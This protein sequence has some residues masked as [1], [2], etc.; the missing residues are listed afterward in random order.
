MILSALLSFFGG[1]AFRYAL[2]RVIDWLEAKQRFRE[3]QARNEQQEKFDQARHVRQI[4]LIKLQSDLK[5]T[6]VKLI[7][8]QQVNLADAQA[9]VEAQKRAFTPTGVRWIDAWNGSIRP[10]A[11]TISLTIWV[12]KIIKAGFVITQWDM[13]LVS[14]I[15][16]F[17]FADR[18]MGKRGKGA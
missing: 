2:G 16:G 5:L 7:G 3:E 8:E 12:A 10:A 18:H 17:F 11:A 9:F 14:G 1:A 15:I 6:E 13:D 4:E